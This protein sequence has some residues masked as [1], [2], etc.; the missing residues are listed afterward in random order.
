MNLIWRTVFNETGYWEAEFECKVWATYVC[1]DDCGKVTFYP[2]NK[3]LGKKWKKE[4]DSDYDEVIGYGPW[5]KVG[6]PPG[7]WKLRLR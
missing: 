6:A 3:P 4:A 7:P 1:R 2:G 5:S